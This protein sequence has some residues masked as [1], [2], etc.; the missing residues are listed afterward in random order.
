M[1][2]T[3]RFDT[4]Q[5]YV[6]CF[7]IVREGDKV[8]MI[9]RKNTNWMDDYWTLPA[10][11]V[12][13][14]ESPRLGAIREA[15]EEVGIDVALDDV[16]HVIS[17]VRLDDD[18]DWVDVYFEA[19]KWSGDAR[20]AEPEKASEMAWHDINNLPDNVVPT[21]KSTLE[22]IAR[23]DNYTEYGFESKTIDT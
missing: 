8:A 3:G 12:E 15:K 20:N 13:I 10:G 5:T 7:M 17:V 2:K 23:G 1:S 14:N 4:M 19:S 16:K 21:V 11:K 6:A 18:S 9:K 22:A